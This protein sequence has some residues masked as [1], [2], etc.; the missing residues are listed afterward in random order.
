M[1][2]RCAK[3]GDEYDEVVKFCPRDGTRL[4]GSHAKPRTCPTCSRSFDGAE[5]CPFDG[6]ALRLSAESR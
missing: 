5:F 6:T 4:D 3:C 2:I 1:N